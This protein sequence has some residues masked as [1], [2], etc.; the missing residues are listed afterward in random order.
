MQINTFRDGG[1][2]RASHRF[3]AAADGQ[4]FRKAANGPKRRV[5]CHGIETVVYPTISNWQRNTPLWEEPHG[6]LHYSR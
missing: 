6:Y 2:P 5:R 4:S 3:V 1:L